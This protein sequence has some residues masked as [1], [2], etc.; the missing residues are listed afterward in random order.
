MRLHAPFLVILFSASAAFGD[1]I[2]V[3]DFA[4]GTTISSS[5]VNSNFDTLVNE[6][7]E[8]DARITA[9][10]QSISAFTQG[11]GFTPVWVDSLGVVVGYGESGGPLVKF[12]ESDRVFGRIYQ[13]AIGNPDSS[14]FSSSRAYYESFDCSGTA[15]LKVSKYSD[16]RETKF[17]L[18]SAVNPNTDKR[19]LPDL[20]AAVQWPFGNDFFSFSDISEDGVTSCTSLNSAGGFDGWGGD[21]VAPLFDSVVDAD[22]G[23][24]PPLRLEWR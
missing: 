6:S 15:Y 1:S 8:N 2:E 11:S 16:L 4:P 21:Y 3:D 24:T 17:S 18:S 23:I 5:A 7:N 20:S 14:G 19:M 22:L 13:V 12:P 10:E 9:N